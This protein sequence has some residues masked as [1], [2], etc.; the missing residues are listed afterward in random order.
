M[1]LPEKNPKLPSI[2]FPFLPTE[3]G[4]RPCGPLT[5][6]WEAPTDDTT[7]DIYITGHLTITRSNMDTFS[8]AVKILTEFQDESETG[9]GEAFRRSNTRN[10]IRASKPSRKKTKDTGDRSTQLHSG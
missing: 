10:S 9:K 3:H 5:L 4:V 6:Q 8:E 2:N 7:V 1:D